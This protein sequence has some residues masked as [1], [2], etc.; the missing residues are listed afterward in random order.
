VI[1]ASGAR[2]VLDV[3][4]PLTELTDDLAH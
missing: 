1:F 2:R 3:D 4:A